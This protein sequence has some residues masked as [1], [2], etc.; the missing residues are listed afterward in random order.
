MHVHNITNA[1][2]ICGRCDQLTGLLEYSEH[3]YRIALPS[4]LLEMTSKFL[5][6][7][8]RH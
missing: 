3:L 8:P 1:T 2:A 4:R 7:R 5:S 6:G